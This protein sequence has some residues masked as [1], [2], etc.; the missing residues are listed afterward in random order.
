MFGDRAGRLY[1]EEES[2]PGT[3]IS[4]CIWRVLHGIFLLLHNSLVRS[5]SEA[6]RISSKQPG[7]RVTIISHGQSWNLL[8]AL[9]LGI[10]L[11]SKVDAVICLPTAPYSLD[12]FHIHLLHFYSLEFKHQTE[13][14]FNDSC[15][16]RRSVYLKVP[17]EITR[18]CVNCGKTIEVF[19]CNQT[20]QVKT[21]FMACQ[22][23]A[24]VQHES[25]IFQALNY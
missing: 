6:K 16:I 19:F 24:V 20:P 22:S 15:Q 8:L 3:T 21:V 9:L 7:I 2:K 10:V 13:M 4:H 23:A 1:R 12:Q 11:L 17:T 25:F 5:Q 14:H 18:S